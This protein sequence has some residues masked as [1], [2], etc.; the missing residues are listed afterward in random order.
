MDIDFRIFSIMFPIMFGFL[1]AFF[2]IIGLRG[3]LTGK[4]FLLS[5]KWLL[6][7]MFAT[8]IPVILF[9]FYFAL[10]DMDLTEMD[11]MEWLNPALFTVILVMM[12]FALKG[13]VAY[14][15]TDTSFREALLAALEKL[16]LPYEETLSTMRLTSIDADLQVSVQSWLGSGMIKVKQR[17]HRSLL[18]EIVAEM[19]RYFSGS[20]TP[21]KLTTCI[22]YVVMG[23]LTVIGGIGMVF[24]FQKI[25][26]KI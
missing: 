3:I 8:F 22:F 16:Q 1:A 18:T 10:P 25:L 13:Y 14:G 6:V 5:N 19:N 23:G 17:E 21:I 4:P 12:C 9:P 2:L 20:S 11:L 24:F 7:L 26:M 15:V